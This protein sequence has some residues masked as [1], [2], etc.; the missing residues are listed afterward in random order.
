MSDPAYVYAVD[1]RATPEA[2]WQ[3][4][5]TP[6]FQAKFWFGARSQADWSKGALVRMEREGGVDFTGEVLDADPPRRLV[7][8]FDAGNGEGPSTVTYDL[9]AQSG[10]TRLT[11]TQDDFVDNSRLRQSVS[12]GWP[13]VLDGLKALLEG[14][15]AAVA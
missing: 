3:A 6:E 7:W 1:I 11:V 12:K 14:E 15:A 4:L 10:V 2:V 9:A 5:T 13:A 8:T